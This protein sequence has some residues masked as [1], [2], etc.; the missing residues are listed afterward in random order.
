[1]CACYS[2]INQI[3]NGKRQKSPA[4][5]GAEAIII[6]LR[7]SLIELTESAE[8]LVSAV[9][10]LVRRQLREPVEVGGK[11]LADVVAHTVE[12][13]EILGNDTVGDL[14]I[15]HIVSRDMQRVRRVR[16]PSRVLPED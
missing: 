2:G 16:D 3:I 13:L 11:S 15:D 4:P 12:M 14:E 10:E 5:F 6:N 7:K 9:P 8:P 1:M